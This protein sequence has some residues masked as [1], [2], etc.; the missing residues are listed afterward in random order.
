MNKPEDVREFLLERVR[1]ELVGPMTADEVLADKPSDKYLT[2]I[3]FPQESRDEADNDELP[4][5]GE[6]DTSEGGPD[7]GVPLSNCK[8]PSSCGLSFQITADSKNNEPPEVLVT[9]RAARYQIKWLDEDGKTLV[10]ERKKEKAKERWV[11]FGTEAKDLPMKLVEGPQPKKPLTEKGF[12]GLELYVQAAKTTSGWAATV[13][14]LNGVK[15]PEEREERES[16]TWFQTG[17]TINPGK[18]WRL[19]GR[20]IQKSAN[21]LDDQTAELIY[22]EALEFAV[23]HTCAAAWNLKSGETVSEVS[24][25]WLPSRPVDAMSAG[26]DKVFDDLRAN[27]KTPVFSARWLAGAKK[28]ELITMLNEVP[29]TYGRWIK[30]EGDRIPSLA[31]KLRPTAERHRK[32][33]V[34]GQERMAKAIEFLKDNDEA[35]RAFQLANEAMAIQRQWARGDADLKWHPFQLAFQLL[36]MESVL[37]R[38]HA[39][40]DRMDLL[41]FPTGGGKTEA[42]LGVIAQLLFHRRLTAKNDDDGA[43]VAVLMRYTL[44]VLTTQQF[45][46]AAALICACELLRRREMLK[47]GNKPFSIGLW[48]GGSAIPNEVTEAHTDPE[49]RALVIRTCPCCGKK[50]KKSDN[51][52]VYAVECVETGCELGKLKEPLPIWTVD[53]DVYRVLPSMVIGTVDKFAQ[54]AR[55]P[56]TGRL[57]GIGTK[58]EPPDL[59]IQDEL[60]LISGP[61][62]T[63]AGLYEVAVDEFCARNGHRP[64]IIGSTATIK[65]A[66]RQ[67]KDLFDRGVYQFP[68]PGLDATNSCFAVRDSLKAGRLYLGVTTAGRSAKFTL[69]AVCASL[70][71]AA[72]SPK[73]PDGERDDYWTLVNYFNSMRELG[74]AHVLMLDDVPKS[75]DEYA[76][77]WGEER[78]EIEEPAELTSRRSQAEIP[79]V[80]AELK[81][82]WKKQD[83]DATDVL[84]S[85]NMIS[86]GVDIPRLGLM[87]VNGQPKAISEYIQATSRVGRDRVPGLVVTV[88]NNNKPRD[89]S[90]YETFTTW[91]GTLYRDVE[92]TSVTPFAPR[93]RDKALR[94]VLV[95]LVR[96]LEPTLSDKPK[97]TSEKRRLVEAR[98]QALM[99]RVK[100]VDAEESDDMENMLRVLLDEWEKRGAIEYYWWDTQPKKSLL[101]S[102]ERLAALRAV[103]KDGN[104]VWPAPNSMRD[105]EPDTEFRLV[106]G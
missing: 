41:W 55:K 89:R 38:G 14:L 77:R 58:H 99:K 56:D 104:G 74:G 13:V 69:Q 96:H 47:G 80:L 7:E 12:P 18:G 78:R 68:P 39:D 31:P 34:E 105:V 76:G 15:G 93:A 70:L 66:D 59:I 36:V 33:W 52:S 50:L 6:D 23:G 17:L 64:K 48:V 61:L 43:G 90:H 11:R 9:V 85:T 10:D 49:Q 91:H 16:K 28:A 83:N 54:I 98:M 81:R 94:A 24:T 100:R 21:S 30:T 67:V 22:R 20:V 87:V 46:R 2:G 103:G 73:I 45:E 72:G 4:Q 3:L 35:R 75:M 95:A 63:I 26:G 1:H 102:A 42:Y 97:L 92:P 65:M 44:R 82:T 5:G 19:A 51:Q 71:Q 60:H 53:G 37:K 27:Q 88:F 86:V 40:R 29:K 84:L 57:F 8:K 62:G 101:I 32:V 25:T 79:T 106:G